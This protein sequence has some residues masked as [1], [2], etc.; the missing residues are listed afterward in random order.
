VLALLGIWREFAVKPAT[1]SVPVRAPGSRARA[2]TVSTVA[3]LACGFLIRPG[4]ASAGEPPAVEQQIRDTVA[5]L[6]AS[7]RPT[8]ADWRE[9]AEQTLAF[10]EHVRAGQQPVPPGPV[11]DALAAVERGAQ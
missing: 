4:P 1:R 6:I 5:R 2:R 7:P 10:G 9:L 11:A 3:L 8:A